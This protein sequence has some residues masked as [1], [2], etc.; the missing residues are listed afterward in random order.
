VPGAA[1]EA[2]R[3]AETRS[4]APLAMIYQPP[5]IEVPDLSHKTIDEVRAE[6]A[7]LLTI[8]NIYNANPGWIVERQF[9][10]RNSNVTVCSPLDLW[11]AAPAP[12]T[13]IVP[14]IVGIP[15]NRIASFLEERHLKYAGSTPK[16]TNQT[17]GS[18]FDQDPKPG[19]PEPWGHEVVAYRA[20]SPPPVIETPT[21]DLNSDATSIKP[22]DTVRFVA[23]LKPY[24]PDAQFVFDFDDGQPAG[25]GGPEATHRFDADRDYLVTVTAKLGNQQVES[26]PRRITVH[27][28]AYT[29][30]VTWTPLYPTQGQPV[31][32]TA[33]LEPANRAI[34]RGPYYF[35]FGGNA[36]P[37]RSSNTY[38]RSFAE[39]G[40]YPVHVM[41][42][43]EHGHLIEYSAPEL[44]VTELPP[45]HHWG[46]ILA[47]SGAVLLIGSLIGF[48]SLRDYV[49]GLVG[50]RATS[51]TGSVDYA[52]DG[53][54]AA[55]G[56]RLERPP[57]DASAEFPGAVVLKVER[58]R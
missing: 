28:I 54:E 57:A 50:V 42:R 5:S 46:K 27:P 20:V 58:I 19:T 24:T 11:M 23:T 51:R 36:K 35:S 2:A 41:L 53:L 43:G 22:G 1:L 21:I 52:G 3:R 31:V 12:R 30:A 40:A 9:P 7:N 8:R 33:T 6:V 17:A 15:E 48:Y 47:L 55:F 32:F 16:E 29:L 45:S 56:F 34:A 26:Q 49:S 38:S 25:P 37:I 13:T 14:N 10:A 39:P 18:I 44:I 4:A